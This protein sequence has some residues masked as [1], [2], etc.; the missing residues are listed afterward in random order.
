MKNSKLLPHYSGKLSHKFWNKVNSIN[1]WKKRE[2]V[3]FWG[4]T[5]QDFESR[6]LQEV[7]DE[8]NS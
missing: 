6:V 8:Q 3:Y 4:C 5:L 1:N 7:N 2:M